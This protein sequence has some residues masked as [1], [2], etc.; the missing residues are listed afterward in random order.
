MIIALKRHGWGDTRCQM[1][2]TTA[3][4]KLKQKVREFK[5]RLGYTLEPCPKT[6]SCRWRGSPGLFIEYH[7]TQQK[8]KV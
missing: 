7:K 3:L 1:P 8:V 5:A 6:V 4:S 2:V